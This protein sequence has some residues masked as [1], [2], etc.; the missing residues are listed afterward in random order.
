MILKFDYYVCLLK[1]LYNLYQFKEVPSFSKFFFFFDFLNFWKLFILWLYLQ[2]I[3]W[4]D[5]FRH[6]S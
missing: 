4:L 1:I 3:K 5:T 6:I 2:E